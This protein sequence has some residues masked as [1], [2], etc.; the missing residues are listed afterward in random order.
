MFV[1]MKHA[2][3]DTDAAVAAF[4]ATRGVTRCPAACATRTTASVPEA[5]RKALTEHFEEIEARRQAK[6][7]RSPFGRN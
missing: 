1:G 5:D 4:I 7:A 6:H 2:N 3:T